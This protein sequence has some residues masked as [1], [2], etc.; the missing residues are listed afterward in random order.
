MRKYFFKIILPHINLITIFYVMHNLHLTYKTSII[1]NF[2][3]T[4]KFYYGNFVKRS[5]SLVFFRYISDNI[6][7]IKYVKFKFSNFKL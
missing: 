5:R 3:L 6:E 2:L 1:D 7:M 4:V